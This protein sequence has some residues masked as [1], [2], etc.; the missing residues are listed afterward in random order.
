MSALIKSA[1]GCTDGGRITIIPHYTA[2]I[3]HIFE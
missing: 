1:N 2:K 3:F